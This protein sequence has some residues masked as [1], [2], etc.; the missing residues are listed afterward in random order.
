MSVETWKKEFYPKPADSKMGVRGA[1]LH[2]LLKWT[3]LRP[4]NM[5]KHDVQIDMNG[6]IVHTRN[7]REIGNPMQWMEIN[8]STCALCQKFIEREGHCL[9]CPLYLHLGQRC[10]SITGRYI[11]PYVK[12][13]RKGAAPMIRALK[14]T[15][16]KY[17]EDKTF[18]RR[19]RPE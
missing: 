13:P 3:G 4:R 11:G 9:H 7:I 5:K 10:D 1:I 17:D 14:A 12:W 19:S 16:K 2:S 15:L 8:S 18:R 6:D